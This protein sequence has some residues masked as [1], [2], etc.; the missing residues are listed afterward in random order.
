M[1]LDPI[2]PLPF[3]EASVGEKPTLSNPSDKSA[4][5]EPTRLRFAG[6]NGDA[7][8]YLHRASYIKEVTDPLDDPFITSSTVAKGPQAIMNRS[9]SVQAD[10]DSET[11]IFKKTARPPA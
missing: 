5:R 9:R 1:K 4:S 3:G 10:S 8:R 7:R 2:W 6:G 11:V